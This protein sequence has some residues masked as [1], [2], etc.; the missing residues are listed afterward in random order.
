MKS[1]PLAL[2]LVAGCATRGAPPATSV[3]PPPEGAAESQDPA[4]TPDEGAWPGIN[5]AERTRVIGGWESEARQDHPLVGIR[6]GVAEGRPLTR[7]E[8]QE[9]ARR[10]R[11]V[12]LGEKHDNPDHHR[13]Q[14]RMLGTLADPAAIVV[15][16]M[17]DDGDADAIP[18]PWATNSLGATPT[19][20]SG[21]GTRRIAWRRR[22]AGTSRAGR[23]GPCTGACSRSPSSTAWSSC[24]A[25]RSATCSRP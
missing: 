12:L 4:G 10:H 23:I 5:D 1:L 13:L 22:S 16:E 7:D 15:Y 6:W 19:S 14:A 25:T 18:T 20:R 21:S 9:R 24:P 8:V 17:L 3:D 11:F 2:A